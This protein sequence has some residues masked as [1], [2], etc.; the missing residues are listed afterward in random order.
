MIS[1]ENV[2]KSYGHVTALD[3]LTM[4]VEDGA[5]YALVGPNGAGKTTA[6][7]ML[8]GLV[9]P[10]SGQV[11]IDDMEA[12]ADVRRL[13]RRIGSV[14]TRTFVYQSIWTFLRT[15]MICPV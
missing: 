1:F 11:L 13:K 5:L 6:L 15:A 14:P 3:G 12:G 10:D 9:Y 4:H 7:R 2:K 8:L